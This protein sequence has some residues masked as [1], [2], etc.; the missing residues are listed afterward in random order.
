[1]G[2]DSREDEAVRIRPGGDTR[3]RR[4][5]GRGREDKA[6]RRQVEEK[7]G[8]RGREEEAGPLTMLFLLGTPC[9]CA[10]RH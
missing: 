2:G 1:M 6:G 7:A 4:P 9:V 8:R 5:G 3:R 10:A